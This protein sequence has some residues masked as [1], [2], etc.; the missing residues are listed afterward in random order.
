MLRTLLPRTLALLLSMPALA[1]A[2]PFQLPE[3]P[4]AFEALEPQID[5]DTMRIHHGRHHQAYVNNLN[6][7]VLKDSRLEGMTLE[8]IQ[9][10]ISQYSEAVRNN[11]GGHYNHS[12]FWSLL[13]PAGDGGAPSEALSEALVQQFGSVDA[14]KQQFE[15]AALSVFGSGWAW[16]IRTDSGELV[17][18]TTANQD[19]PLMDVISPN[20][21]PLL[22]IDV[23]EHAYYLKYQ[24]V[25][26]DYVRGWWPIVNWK[27]VNRRFAEGP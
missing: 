13:S 7:A 3:L 12:L 19:N 6:S 2:A 21:E 8:Q 23:W 14:F 4:Y 16:L 1:A 22:A 20:G 27:E 26:A 24:N 9:R 10:G 18:S 25:R 17:I 5:A 15:D 11:G